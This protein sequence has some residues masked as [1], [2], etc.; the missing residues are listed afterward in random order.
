MLKTE[1]EG[2]PQRIMPSLY[3]VRDLAIW[4]DIFTE[5]DDLPIQIS[6]LRV[7]Y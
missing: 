7:I 3:F 5:D 4:H 1:D 2:F 6:I